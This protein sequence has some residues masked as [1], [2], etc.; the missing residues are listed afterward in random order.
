MKRGLGRMRHMHVRQLW[1]QDEVKE[2]RIS[3]LGIFQEK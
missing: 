2:G 1:L 3:A